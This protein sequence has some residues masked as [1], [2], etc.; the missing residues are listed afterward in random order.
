MKITK[1]ET[2][3][4]MA[5][6][7][8]WVFV[9]ITTDAG[10]T[11]YSECTDSFGSNR[12]VRAAIHDLGEKI[13]G[14]NPLQYEKIFWDLYRI[15]RQSA[16][17]IIQKAIGGIENALLDIK[18]KALGVSVTELF[19]GPLRDELRIYWSHC[20][21]T[22]ART[23][24]HVGKEPLLT[25]NDVAA[26]G[27]EV[28]DRGYTALKT[29]IITP[30]NPPTVVSQGFR[31]DGYDQG[32]SRKHLADMEALIGTFRDAVGPEVDILLDLNFH[33]KPEGM[34]E[35]GRVLEQF[36]LFWLELDVYNEKALRQVKDSVN[37]PIASCEDLFTP[38]GYR[39]YFEAR[40]VD[41]AVIDVLWNGFAQSKKIAD[42]ADAYE[43]SVAPHNHYSPLSTLISA[44]WCRAIP[45]MRIFELDV[46]DIPWRDDLLTAAPTIKNGHL[47]VPDGPGWGADLNEE[48][49]LAHGWEN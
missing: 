41:V 25:L 24:K 19:G 38:R 48:V 18:G 8:A 22:R 29:N 33:F 4:C 42:L 34:V 7:R 39:P 46:D 45:N 15:T 9:K 43:L 28:K 3:A 31:G 11:G 27:R 47:T 49:V 44:Q 36:N 32:I 21:T 30:G 1:V 35:V 6:W 5:G 10:I 23:W 26:L 12:A 40:G 2:L 20:G 17:G 13:V 16:G 14:A 37:I